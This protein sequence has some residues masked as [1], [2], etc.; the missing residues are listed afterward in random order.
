[1]DDQS[2]EKFFEGNPSGL[3]FSKGTFTTQQVERLSQV[4]KTNHTITSL[5]LTGCL[6]REENAR[7]LAEAFR[8]NTTLR[9]LHLGMNLFGGQGSKLIIDS[10]V[11]CSR[12]WSLDM[13]QNFMFRDQK[14]DLLVVSIAALV[15][16]NHTLMHLDVSLN[17]LDEEGRSV[18]ERAL[19]SFNGSLTSQQGLGTM[20]DMT[21]TR[22]LH[23]HRRVLET[24]LAML[25]VRWLKKNVSSSWLVCTM[26]K[27]MFQMIAK[28]LWQTKTDLEAWGERVRS[29]T[30]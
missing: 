17:F 22:N 16:C 11:P 21:C 23:M 25:A 4:L 26:P 1:M 2:F 9:Y 8:V 28:S 15:T 13:R 14:D 3:D 12:V 29:A 10:L 5:D 19:R 27:E 7:V 20:A 30:R 24:V 18:I 6:L